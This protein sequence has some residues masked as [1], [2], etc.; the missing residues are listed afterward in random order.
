VPQNF[1]LII[2]GGTV[3]D[4]SGSDGARVDI[5][6]KGD[7]IALVGDASGAEAGITIDARN[8]AVAPGFIDV[9]AHDDALIFAEPDMLGKS[10]QGVTTVINGNCDAGVVPMSVSRRTAEAG[11]LPSWDSY[12]GYFAAIE[13]HPPI[14]QRG[15]VGRL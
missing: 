9:H 12:S 11:S 3:Y 4:G 5:G 8:H 10:M 14:D 7:R 2:R 6:V 13:Q 15:L 1:D